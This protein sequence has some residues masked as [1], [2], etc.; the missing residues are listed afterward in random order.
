[1]KTSG[2]LKIFSAIIFLA[3]VLNGITTGNAVQQKPNIVFILTD[4]LGINDLACYGRTEHRTPNIDKLANQGIRFTA[5]YCAL[6]ICSPSRAAILTGKNPAKLHITTFLPG[7]RDCPAQKVLQ[8]VINQQLPLEEVTLAEYLKKAGYVTGCFGKWHLGGKGFGP[9]EQGFDFYHPGKAVTQPSETEGGKGEYDLTMAAIKFI[10]E[11]SDKPFF[12][13]LAHNTPHIPYSAKP[14]L[15]EKNKNALEP[16][17]AALI[18]TLDDTVGILMKKLEEKGL[19]TNTI[20]IFASDNG[21]LHVPELKHKIITHNTPYR[22]GKGYLYEGGLRVPLIV[23]WT[24][25][26]PSGKVIDTPVVNTDF[27]PTLL[28]LVGE[29]VPKDIDG[30]SFAKTLLSGKNEKGNKR[31]FFHFPH[32]TN[33]GGRPS[34][35][36]IDGKWKLIK[37][38]DDDSVELY[39]LEND[40]GETT[41]LAEKEP[42]IAKRLE[43]ALL[44]WIKKEK[45]QTNKP[46]PDFNPELYR[47]L[48]VDIDTSKYNAAKSTPEMFEKI[49]EWRRLMD[50]VVVRK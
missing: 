15:V 4:D 24:G 50:E 20:V 45:L 29:K 36:V 5:S 34:G 6:P 31:L 26:I 27:L 39:N 44:D 32:Y 23:R 3:L 49:L 1:M 42:A 11:N 35:A 30:K 43:K 14:A 19:S 46:N 16:V 28:E 33:Q 41:N 9:L 47:K 17:Y 48:Y 8:P 12:V 2:F 38:Y 7:R 25:K 10:E 18:E 21:G 22:A 40:I 13:Y 37:Y